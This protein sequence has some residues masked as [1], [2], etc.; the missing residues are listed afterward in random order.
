MTAT[1]VASAAHA[2][3]TL[4]IVGT[5]KMSDL[6]PRVGGDLAAVHVNR[7]AHWWKL[8][9]NGVTYSQEHSFA[10]FENGGFSEQFFN[11]ASTATVTVSYQT[12]NGSA[13]APKDYTAKSGTLTFQP[14]QTTKTIALTIKG[15]RQREPNETFTVR[16]NNAV[17]A[18]LGRSIGSATILNDD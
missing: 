1:L 11:R 18:N 6:Y 9:L 13:V 12:A 3:D 8:T 16:L 14:G 10:E 5:F 4:S 15:D 2:Q 7:N 17:G